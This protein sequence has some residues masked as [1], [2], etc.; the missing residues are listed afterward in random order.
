[1][2]DITDTVIAFMIFTILIHIIIITS[3]ARAE[4]KMKFVLVTLDFKIKKLSNRF[5]FNAY[6]D[7][8][9]NL[10]KYLCLKSLKINVRCASSAT[11]HINVCHWI[12][13]MEKLN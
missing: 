11:I 8:H 9:L 2:T 12:K 6:Y 13:A 7:D 4:T 1:M 5:K 3:I 10:D